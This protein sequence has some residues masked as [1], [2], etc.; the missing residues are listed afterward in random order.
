MPTQFP[1]IYSQSAPQT[2]S[3][4]N[5][6]ASQNSNFPPIAPQPLPPPIQPSP[7][8][9]NTSSYPVSQSLQSITT[10]AYSNPQTL[11]PAPLPNHLQNLRPL[12]RGGLG[13]AHPYG[14]NQL[15]SQSQFLPNQDPEPTHV[16]GQQGRRGVLPPAP[17]R[18]APGSGKAAPTPTKNADGKFDCPHCTKTYLHL[19]HLKRHL[20]RHTGDRPYQ[21]ILCKD[22]FS[23]SDILKRH[24]Q[25]CSLRRG[26]PTGVTHL[27]GSR[28]N[29]KKNRLSAGNADQHTYLNPVNGPPNTYGETSFTFP[30]SSSGINTLS[31][32]TNLPSFPDSNNLPALSNRASRANSDIRPITTFHENRRS[33]SGLDAFRTEKSGL[34]TGFDGMGNR[35]LSDGLSRQLDASAMSQGQGY[36]QIPQM[37]HQDSARS[38]GESHHLVK[39]EDPN[40]LTFGRNSLSNFDNASTGQGNNLTWD[41]PFQQQPQETFMFQST[42]P[43]N[44]NSL[45][46]EHPLNADGTQATADMPFSGLYS[47]SNNFGGEQILNW[48]LASTIERDPLQQKAD[49]LLAFCSPHITQELTVILS[50][51]NITHFL[52]LFKNFQA[53]WP[54]LHMPTF[55]PVQASNSLLLAII[56]VGAVYSDRLT[57]EHVRNVMEIVRTVVQRSSPI[58]ARVNVSNSSPAS[59]EP[60]VE[61]IQSLI[62]LCNLFLWHGTKAQNQ[63]ARSEHPKIAKYL[64]S[65]VFLFPKGLDR[66]G[67]SILH[68][69]NY[70]FSQQLTDNRPWD[71][72]LWVEQEKFSRAIYQTYLTDT[73]MVIFFNY[74]PKFDASRIQ[75]PLPADD[76]AWEAK[77]AEDCASAIG[78]NGYK[79][80]QINVSGTNSPTQMTLRDALDILMDPTKEF[81]PRATNAYSKFILIHA[82]CVYIIKAHRERTVH[83]NGYQTSQ[84]Y[85]SSGP[86]TP[87]SS[88]DWGMAEG[89]V[90]TISN[91]NSGPVTPI[92]GHFPHTHGQQYMK[93]LTHALEKWKKHWDSDLTSQ[94]PWQSVFRRIGFCRD[95]VHF[96]YLAYH[97]LNR[98]GPAE[99]TLPPEQRYGQVFNLLKQITSQIAS[100]QFAQDF[101]AVGAI[102]ENYGVKDLT[103]DMKLLFTPIQQHVDHSV[104]TVRNLPLTHRV[105]QYI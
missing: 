11:A 85:M 59:F 36:N 4:G 21:C 104:E 76:V 68:Q 40:Q 9:V 34:E 100:G 14:S 2:P 49:S 57:K 6:S 64:S 26:N 71:W 65:W 16:V 12:P 44:S 97:F 50:M 42:V 27:Q 84:G 3:S 51:D 66:P 5:N 48:G 24:F 25:K 54:L 77:N 41:E 35:G 89:S 37:F 60:E 94:Y 13:L 80:A 31:S 29:L 87:R 23:R 73:A 8:L 105:A 10:S 28:A 32:E 96:Y 72:S 63:W 1:P 95:A 56:C 93:T 18:V 103:L 86:S 47:L 81:E 46:A 102:D 82:L 99:L 58:Y 69:P 39:T 20:L 101:S 74:T 19:K 90:G 17:G 30:S 43:P 83:N 75:L 78:A 22:T 53:H 55:D 67:A 91:N 62:L 38:G 7:Y 98:T 88:G 92:E 79:A 52:D 70:S 61:D 45:K 15:P 33:M